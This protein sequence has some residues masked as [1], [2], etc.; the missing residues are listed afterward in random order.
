MLRLHAVSLLFLHR[1][2]RLAPRRNLTFLLLRRRDFLHPG[3]PACGSG[4]HNPLYLKLHASPRN[5]PFPD[6]ENMYVITT[7]FVGSQVAVFPE[8]HKLA[9]WAVLHKIISQ[10]TYI[11][12]LAWVYLLRQ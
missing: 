10:L 8:E 7:R 3:L 11:P 5:L 1:D 12:G 2:C 9:V 4:W 6:H